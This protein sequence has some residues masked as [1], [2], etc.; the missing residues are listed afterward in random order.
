MELVIMNPHRYRS[1]ILIRTVLI[2]VLVTLTLFSLP[3]VSLASD[4]V[5]IT[6]TW[7]GITEP[8][9]IELNKGDRIIGDMSIAEDSMYVRVTSP[10]GTIIVEEIDVTSIHVDYIAEISGT[11][12]F[13]I[14][15]LFGSGNPAY[16]IT[17][18]I[19]PLGSTQPPIT[20]TTPPPT[21]TPPSDSIDLPFWVWPIGAFIVL[22]ILIVFS[23]V[24]NKVRRK[25]DYDKGSEDTTIDKDYG[26]TALIE[27][28]PKVCKRCK[29]TGQI[30][31]GKMPVQ[32]GGEVVMK[33]I[34]YGCLICGGTGWV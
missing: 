5:I 18:T 12:S 15:F 33:E 20:T 31:R 2:T 3:S 10:S 26:D 24:R 30:K 4:E 21:T 32:R 34:Y 7:N 25:K 6:G 16:N 29:G 17:Y 22:G 14:M 27:D 13:A 19:Y 23:V 9:P 11:I 8:I 1:G 28:F